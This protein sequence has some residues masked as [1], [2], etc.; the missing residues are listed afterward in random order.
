METY[1][2]AWVQAHVDQ[3][4]D[5]WNEC[6]GPWTPETRPWSRGEQSANEEAYDKSL[7]QLEAALQSP[8][9]DDEITAAFG[10][11]CTRAFHLDEQGTTLLTGGFLPI[12]VSLSTWAR[13]FD[14]E[15]S[16]AAIIQAAR[17]AW[18]ACGLQ[19]LF[20]VPMGLTPSI[21]GY[22]LI[23]PYSDNLLD[24]ESIPGEPKLGFSRRLRRRLLG[25]ELPADGETERRVWSLVTL[26]EEEYDR[27][28]YPNVFQSLLAIHRAQ[29]QS[30]GQLQGQHACTDALRVSCA[31]GGSSVLADACFAYGSLTR[32]ES[33]FAFEWGVLLQCGDDL[34]DVREDIRH[35][36]TTLFSGAAAAGGRL[37]GLT[38]QLL[39][40]GEHAG[41]RMNELSGGSA[42][43]KEL[44]M[45]SWRSLIFGAVADSHEFFSEAFLD[46]VEPFSP[47]RFGFLRERKSR[48]A[49][50]QGL[51]A[52][53]FNA[54]SR[55]RRN[56]GHDLPDPEEWALPGVPFAA[57]E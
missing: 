25:E 18:T 39:R 8:A 38:A 48:L 40:F 20:N 22:S 16:M 50:R 55:S 17:N 27:T 47:F 7:A 33:R 26:I 13:R 32:L 42:A 2:W 46:S 49:G 43:F 52:R 5:I 34:Q 21:L 36:S 57:V 45:T 54:L 15:L 23:Y 37:D 6:A 9:S 14:P 35:G 51:Y 56:Y 41:R 3:T 53:L 11:F 31:K 10:Q 29:E 30:L 28:L 4:V 12:G 24:D 19:P 1:D 44:L